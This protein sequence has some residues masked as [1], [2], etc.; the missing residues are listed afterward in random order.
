[1]EDRQAQRDGADAA[2]CTRRGLLGG[3]AATGAA[4]V[5]GAPLLRA[6]RADGATP[7]TP[8]APEPEGIPAGP[9]AATPDGRRVW[10]TD[11]RGTTITAHSARTLRRG[12]SIDVG[13]GPAAIAIAP[14]GLTALVTTA[15]HDRPGLTLVELL[16]AETDRVDVGPDP[17]AV[18]FTASGRTA[19][20]VGRGPRG[21]LTRVLPADGRVGAPI[22]LGADPR[23][24]ALDPRGRF[25]LVALGGA[26]A[27]AVVDLRTGRVRR[28]IPT[29]AF[30]AQLAIS[31]DG[32]R[33]LLTHNGF[34]ARAVSLLDLRRH[35]VVRR[36]R[37][38][39]DP[40][41]VAFS[42]SGAVA[43]VTAAGVGTAT[44]LD[45]RTGRRR[46][47]ARP[48]GTPRAIAVCGTRAVLADARTGALTA[49][50]LGMNA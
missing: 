36:I 32:R 23:G 35:A 26:A 46:R 6:G 18:A 2:G 5:L 19:W 33:A 8:C 30:P 22:A 39:T 10:T 40:A 12:R 25:A 48:G 24:L 41:G 42:R 17:G 16:T 7:V 11:V 44:L 47:T 14:D 27:V 15:A 1:M 49:I 4:G 29:A 21:T 31:P 50:R 38:G 43:I 45:G 20:V 28:R 3:A 37:V 13:G 9:L 34:G